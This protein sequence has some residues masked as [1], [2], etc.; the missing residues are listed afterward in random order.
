MNLEKARDSFES[1]YA[2]YHHLK[3]VASLL[4]WDSRTM[5]P[6]GASAQRGE[7]LAFLEGEAHAVLAH[8][9]F[10]EALE[11]LGSRAAELDPSLA[12]A[13]RWQLPRVRRKA[14]VPERLVRKKAELS[15]SSQNLWIEA[16]KQNDFAKFLPALETMVALARET[17]QALSEPGQSVYEGLLTEY[18]GSF[19][20]ADLSRLLEGLRAELVPLVAE[21]VGRGQPRPDPARFAL[22]PDAQVALNKKILELCGFDFSRG[23][24]DVSVHPFCGGAA[25]DVRITSR[26]YADDFTKSLFATLHEAGHGMYEQGLHSLVPH[27]ALRESPG[28]GF[29]ESQS[30]FW[31]NPVGRSREFLALILEEAKGAIPATLD[32]LDVRANQVQPGY[33]RVEAD[34]ATYNLHIAL[35]FELEQALIAGKLEPRDLSEAWWGKIRSYFG[36]ERAAESQ[37]CLQ[38]VHWSVGY[39]GYFPTYSLGNLIAAQMHER[40]SRELD[41]PALIRSRRLPELRHWLAEKVY[42]HGSSRSTLETAESASGAPLGHEAFIRYLKA[43]HFGGRA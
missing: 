38:D 31:E 2:R 21:V 36:L 9:A 7:Q 24:L 16:R 25:G 10:L 41:I 26:Y 33:I 30:R 13:V 35:R 5:M 27:P 43:K 42:R 29:H 8:P 1:S 3:S 23:R 4:Y 14:R 6:P 18:E 20:L 37:G 12:A 34:E 11:E 17:G 32:E 28:M 19:P 22:A 40:A 15:V 39:F